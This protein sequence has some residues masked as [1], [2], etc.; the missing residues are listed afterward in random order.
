MGWF[1][2]AGYDVVCHHLQSASSSKTNADCVGLCLDAFG[3]L[4]SVR[5]TEKQFGLWLEGVCRVYKWRYYHTW[6]SRHSVGGYPDYTL[7]KG[8]N[9]IFA[10][11]KVGRNTLTKKQKEWLEA[12]SRVPGVAA[13]VWYPKDRPVVEEL[14]KSR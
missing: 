12:F 11:L 7:V 1:C 14:L 6:N 2:S 3:V 13:Y 8:E 10:E 5:M 4:V 9:L